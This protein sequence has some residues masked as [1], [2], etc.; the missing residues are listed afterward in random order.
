[1]YIFTLVDDVERLIEKLRAECGEFRLAML[2]N[3]SLDATSNWNLIVSAPWT[4]RLGVA[5]ATHN[6]ATALHESLGLENQKAI[7]RITVLAT[8]DPFVRD[9]IGCIPRRTF[10]SSKSPLAMF[11][12]EA[13]SSCIRRKSPSFLGYHSSLPLTCHPERI[14]SAIRR[15]SRSES[16][17]PSSCADF[18]GQSAIRSGSP[19]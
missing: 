7:S 10:L 14:L 11:G 6:I 9:I 17:D 5:K 13:V 12:R 15:G 8:D 1:M 3:S 18:A 2:Y 19:S 4:D 16:K